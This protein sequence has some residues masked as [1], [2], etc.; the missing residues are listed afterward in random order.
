MMRGA[1]GALQKRAGYVPLGPRQLSDTIA[2]TVQKHMYK[3]TRLY[4]REK[5]SRGWEEQSWGY[6]EREGEKRGKRVDRGCLTWPL[7]LLKWWKPPG[8]SGC[9]DTCVLIL[10][11]V[12]T[13]FQRQAFHLST[14]KES[15]LWRSTTAANQSLFLTFS[16]LEGDL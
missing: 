7:C 15:P 4:T 6:G 2:Y 5:C 16:Y 8:R 9:R 1:K 3:D 14:L 12:Q 11:C 13:R 10:H